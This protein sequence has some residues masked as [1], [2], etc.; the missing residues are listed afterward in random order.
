MATESSPRIDT[1][2][3]FPILNLTPDPNVSNVDD[4]ARERL[5][6]PLLP[7]SK[8]L[9]SDEPTEPQS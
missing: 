9:R 4:I 5:S 6:P 3:N 8:R 2:P 1:T 7:T